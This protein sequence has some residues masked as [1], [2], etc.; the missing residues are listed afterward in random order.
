MKKILGYLFRSI[1]VIGVLVITILLCI[2][3]VKDTKEIKIYSEESLNKEA[4]AQYFIDTITSKLNKIKSQ[5]EQD[6]GQ[7]V[8]LADTGT[9]NKIDIY[10]VT[11][12]N[13]EYKYIVDSNV[14]GNQKFEIVSDNATQGKYIINP[15]DLGLENCI[16]T[17]VNGYSITKDGTVEYK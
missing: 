8:E 15:S 1:I 6:I 5:I 17:D 13:G 2:K 14:D 9:I 7:E 10:F 12:V 16:L 11:K 4:E 3:I